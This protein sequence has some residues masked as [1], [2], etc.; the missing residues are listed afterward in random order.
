MEASFITRIGLILCIMLL[1]SCSALPNAKSTSPIAEVE[2]EI[3]DLINIERQA[4]GLTM[5]QRDPSLDEYAS[6]YSASQFSEALRRSMNLK[7][8]LC[9]TWWETYDHGVA[10]LYNDTAQKQVEYCISELELREAI[11]RDDATATGIGTAVIG[12]TIY[13]T[14][15]FDVLNTVEGDGDPIKLYDNAA[16]VN[17]SWEELK[18]FILLDDTDNHVYREGSF[19]CTDYAA[20]L[21]NRAEA[22]GITSAYVNIDFVGD[23]PGHALNAFQTTDR[24]LVYI[25]CTGK[26]LL[27]VHSSEN[28]SGSDIAN[29][30]KVAYVQEQSEYGVI[31]IEQATS[32][33]YSYY[34]QWNSKWQEY[35]DLL[36]TYNETVRTH[37]ALQN[38][39]NEKI[40]AFNEQLGGR[41]SVPQDEYDRLKAQE[42]E[43]NDLQAD[44]D[45]IK[46]ELAL[47]NATLDTMISELGESRWT[48]P[49]MVNN[50]YVHW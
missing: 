23:T 48:S 29:H 42:E 45:E 1:T 39:I 3:F 14:Q 33:E 31:S 44:L 36:D 10:N 15:V 11:L 9:N 16:A 2:D 22:A 32:F 40:A 43:I 49:G 5:L 7:Y 41:E 35:E 12:S 30:D 50:I 6:K 46:A 21:H 4:A 24:G 19:V 26:G 37:N 34:E 47:L 18:S 38:S 28:A 17:P 27:D 25:D 13:F 8:L 20:I